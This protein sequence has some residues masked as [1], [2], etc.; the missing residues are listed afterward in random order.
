MAALRL[1]IVAALLALPLW[2][3]HSAP[4]H[5]CSCAGGSL[6]EQTSA[7]EFIVIAST[8]DFRLL[9]PVPTPEPLS[10]PGVGRVD[11]NGPPAAIDIVV[12]EYL[13]GTGPASLTVY[14]SGTTITVSPELQ[15]DPSPRS[16]A[17]CGTF[18]NLTA[19]YL[20]FLY[21]APE[22]LVSGGVCGGSTAITEYNGAADYVARVREAVA[23]GPIVLPPTGFRPSRHDNLPLI[24]LATA[25]A[26]ACI[27][28]AA[29][30]AFALRRRN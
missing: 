19:R 29:N 20:L 23:A 5:A 2:V 17:M 27:G 30:A 16:G 22:G 28:L 13:K 14:E 6:Q 1:L 12:H 7:A 21:R 4:A 11:S 24:P 10:Q 3:A 15:V 18:D 8:T 25:S 26:L 9:G